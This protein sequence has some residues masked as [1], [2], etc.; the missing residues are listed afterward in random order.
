MTKKENVNLALILL[1]IAIF[2][3]SC[4][5]VKETVKSE[6]KKDLNIDSDVLVANGSNKGGS[7]AYDFYLGKYEVTQKE[8]EKVMGF[9]PS[10][11]AGENLPV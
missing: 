5:Q 1:A 7:I 8:F 3:S 11:F 10:H 9:N 6:I 2:A 4:R